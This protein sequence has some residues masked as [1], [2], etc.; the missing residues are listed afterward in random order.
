[1]QRRATFECGHDRLREHSVLDALEHS[2]AP[3]LVRYTVAALPHIR[4]GDVRP[5]H[6]D[7]DGVLRV[8]LGQPPSLSRAR[9]SAL[10][11]RGQADHRLRN[12]LSNPATYAN[13]TDW[14]GG[15][16]ANGSCA[17]L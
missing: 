1:M 5:A 14:V 16:S 7:E 17:T 4:T 10:R 13:A 6:F 3:V 11:V 9:S 15:V 12:S 2:A 8:A